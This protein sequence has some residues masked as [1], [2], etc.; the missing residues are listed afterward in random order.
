MA[1]SGVWMSVEQS[2]T[3]E[4]SEIAIE[5]AAVRSGTKMAANVIRF[6]ESVNLRED[7]QDLQFRQFRNQKG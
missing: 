5:G 7:L 3:L 4:A 1:A 6:K 2:L